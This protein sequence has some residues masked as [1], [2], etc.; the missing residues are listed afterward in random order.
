MMNM[1]ITIVKHFVILAITFSKT[2]ILA[3]SYKKSGNPDLCIQK[4]KDSDSSCACWCWWSL[5]SV[6]QYKASEKKVKNF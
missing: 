4:L 5:S 2:A 3:I 1:E 6:A